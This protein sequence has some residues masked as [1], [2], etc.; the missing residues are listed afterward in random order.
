MRAWSN[1]RPF[2]NGLKIKLIRELDWFPVEDFKAWLGFFI[3]FSICSAIGVIVSR[4]KEKAEDR[5]MN[6]AME[7]YNKR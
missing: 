2:Y 6:K 5:K 4:L 1:S 3:S 7:Q